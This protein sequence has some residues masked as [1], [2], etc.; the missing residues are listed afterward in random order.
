MARFTPSYSSLMGRLDEVET[1]RLMAARFEKADAVG[2]RD[3]INALC[4]ASVVMLSSHLEGYIKDLGELAIDSLHLNGEDRS[5]LAPRFFF[6][7]S[8]P[9]IDG[10]HESPDPNFIAEKVFSFLETE[11]KF[12]SKTGAFPAQIDAEKFN[13]GFSNPAFAKINSYIQR[14]GFIDFKRE[15]K[16][17]LRADFQVCVNMIDNLVGIRNQ[18]AHGTV[19]VTYTPRELKD[20]VKLMKLFCSATDRAFA[21][22]WKTKFI[23]IR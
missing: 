9:D 13:R 8:K 20:K 15:L 16:K 3:A 19:G 10:I 1:L 2:N 6:H 23:T 12:W 5:K 17:S 21:T 7:I 14:F 18:I 11:A 22:W 4:R